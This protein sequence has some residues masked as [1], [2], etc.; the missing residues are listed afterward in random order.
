M[1][2]I[3]N[4]DE[5]RKKMLERIGVKNFEELLS[6]VPKDLRLKKPLNLPS[7]LSELEVKKLMQTNSNKNLNTENYISFLG[8]GCYDHYIPSAVDAIILRPEFYTAYTPYQ[9]EASQGTLQTIYEYQSM[10]CELTNME[11]TNA[12]MYDGG[13]ALAEACHMAS[14]IM[15]REEILISEGVNPSYINCVETYLG[16]NRVKLIPLKNGRTDINV[17]KDILNSNIA[18]VVIQHPNFFGIL[19][20]V[21]KIESLAH[22]KNSLYIG[23]VLP[24]SLGIL[25]P[26]GDWGADIVVAEGQSLGIPQSL[27]G[28]GLGILS[29]KK[30]FI[31]QMPGRIIGKTQDTKGRTGFVMTLQTREQHIRREKATSNIC[32]NE[33]LCAIAACVYLTIMGK[34]G[35]KEVSEQCYSKAH[36]L[37]DRIKE[38]SGFSL[39]YKAPFFNEFV[40][41]TPIEAERVVQN[42]I[43]DQIFAGVP[44]SRFYKNRKRELL[45]AVTE[46]RT[47]RELDY[48]V[49]KLTQKE[50]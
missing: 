47:R 22:S 43:K 25:K 13:S 50:F 36:C 1:P 27:G 18:C 4:T 45:I 21:A 20:P 42:L 6:P 9:A 28:P 16:K 17:L 19:E 37:A 7:P 30:E 39:A 26:P 33:G 23:V 32:T 46:K 3:P 48:F 29:A 31:R 35:I 49:E 38:I 10:I 41:Q 40:V 44:I 34:Q 2:F 11:V 14:S 8:A 15:G 5:D 24:I 12:S